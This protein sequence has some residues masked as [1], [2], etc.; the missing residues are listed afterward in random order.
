MQRSFIYLLILLFLFAAACSPAAASTNQAYNFFPQSTV[1]ERTL[2]VTPT[3]KKPTVTKSA[4]KASVT[5]TL[6]PAASSTVYA[7]SPPPQASQTPTAC[8]SDVCTYASQFFLERPIDI[9]NN[10]RIDTS[11]RFGSTQAGKRDPHHGVEFLNSIG[12]PVLAAADGFVVVAGEDRDPVSE[13]GVWPIQFYGPYSYFYGNLVVIEHRLPQGLLQAFPD[14]DEKIFTLY[15]HLSR[16]SVEV[17]EHVKTGHKIGEVGMTGI[18]EGSHLHFEVRLGENTYQNSR[19]PELWLRPKKDENNQGM[20]GIAGNL[21]DSFG[22]N[23][24]LSSIV[25]AYL[26]DGPD[27]ASQQII[28]LISYEEKALLGQPPWREGRRPA[29]WLVSNHLSISGITGEAGTSFS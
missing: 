2:S 17:G 21:I 10:D 6:I 11:Y 16:I 8:P 23:T 4:T 12:T 15:G 25:L 3:V 28:S 18:A 29:I 14:L 22:N 7:Y 5:D 20:G 19:N 1:V 13:H 9:E 26:P 24:Q 27:Q